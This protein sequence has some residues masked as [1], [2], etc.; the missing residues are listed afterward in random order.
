MKISF[1]MKRGKTEAEIFLV[2]SQDKPFDLEDAVGG[3]L[4]DIVS[5]SLR[6]TFLKL[7]NSNPVLILDEPCKFL[8][9]G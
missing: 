1:E 4:S 9:L 6:L 2:D 7:S 3:G 5:L 8:D